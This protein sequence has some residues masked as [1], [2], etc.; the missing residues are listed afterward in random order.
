MTYLNGLAFGLF[1]LLASACGPGPI[2][3]SQATTILGNPDPMAQSCATGYVR[4]S[5]HYC[6]TFSQPSTAGAGTCQLFLPA[7]MPASATAV[8]LLFIAQINSSNVAGV[9]RQMF[10]AIYSDVGCTTQVGIGHLIEQREFVATVAN[11]NIGYAEI[12]LVSMPVVGGGIRYTPTFTNC[13]N[14]SFGLIL[15]GYYD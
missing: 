1:L 4:L 6:A 9:T 3:E 15:M 8:N 13:A 2:E 10:M 7:N 5:P 14:C 11:T 12:S